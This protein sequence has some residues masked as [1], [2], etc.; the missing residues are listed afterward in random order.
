MARWRVSYRPARR[1]V[2]GALVGSARRWSR[3]DLPWCRVIVRTMVYHEF[4]S[5]TTPFNDNPVMSADGSSCC[6][7]RSRRGPGTRPHRTGSL[8]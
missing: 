2:A 8:L 4:T 1:A 6:L 3:R 7:S 5:L